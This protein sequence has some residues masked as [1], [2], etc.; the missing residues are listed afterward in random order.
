MKA[1][2]AVTWILT[3]AAAAQTFPISGVVVD[4]QSGVPINGVRVTL[5]PTGSR[6]DQASVVTG[7]DGRFSFEVPQGKYA[8]TGVRSGLRQGFGRSGPMNSFGSAIITGADQDTA[9]LTFRW[10]STGAI[11][12]NVTDDRGEPVENALVQLIVSTVARGRKHF[13]TVGW[14]W[15]NDEGNYRFGPLPAGTYYLAVTGAPWYSARLVS[16]G[17]S[18]PK[19]PSQPTPAYAPMYYPSAVDL[20]DAAPLIVGQGSEA[21]ADFRLLTISGVTLQVNCPDARGRNGLLSVLADGIEGVQGFQRQLNFTGPSQAIAGV[22]PG[23]YIVRIAGTGENPFSVRKTIDVGASDVVIDLAM[24]PPPTVAGKVTFKNAGTKPRST[25]YAVLVNE[26]TGGTVARPIDSDGSFAWPAVTVGRYR[27]EVSGTDGYFVSQV[28][29]EGA[30]LKDG[31]VDVM[32]GAA[33]RLDV[34]V[35][36]ETGRLKGFVVNGDKPAPGVLVVLAPRAASADPYEYRGFQTESD[37]SFDFQN[38]RAGDYLLFSVDN[39][40]FEYANP[41]AV[42]IYLTSGLAVRIDAHGLYT[43]RITLSAP[44][45]QGQVSVPRLR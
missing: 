19:G 16:Q 2:L 1:V 20:R 11:V 7:S 43:E 36:D 14:L 25:M 39:P 37:G 6:N 9:H 4:A 5:T 17:N 29:V 22:P 13:G 27:P 45:A 24:Q 34:V 8:L 31:V 38:I 28:S 21:R 44:A 3:L 26:A 41:D 10:F 15:T 40:D 33:V 35:S 30:T 42:R 12:G 18:Q 23:R 32:D